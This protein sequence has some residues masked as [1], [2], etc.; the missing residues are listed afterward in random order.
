[1]GPLGDLVP[2]GANYR[3]RLTRW[4]MGPRRAPRRGVADFLSAKKFFTL[5][6][7]PREKLDT[8]KINTKQRK[9]IA[10]PMWTSLHID[11]WLK[12]FRCEIDY[13][14]IKN[15]LH[16]FSKK[17]ISIEIWSNAKKSVDYYWKEDTSMLRLSQFDR[18]T[19][20][21]AMPLF[22]VFTLYKVV[23]IYKFC[24]ISTV[25]FKLFYAFYFI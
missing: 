14:S 11:I 23:K 12:I 21:E 7:A 10:S 22:V 24:T 1:M 9:K 19:V 13:I 6:T 25:K 3:S 20:F 18:K 8:H 4:G 2:S 17:R 5:E 16:F 15:M